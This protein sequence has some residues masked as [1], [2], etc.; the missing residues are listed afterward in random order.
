MRILTGW[1]RVGRRGRWLAGGAVAAVAGVLGIA[2]VLQ[3]QPSAACAAPPAAGTTHRGKATFYTLGGGGGN[4]S[5]DGPPV[6]G[7][8][9]ALGPQQYADAAA[10]GGYLDVTGPKG[11][12]RVK[13]ID[14]CPECPAE[15]IDLSAAAF[16]KIADPVQGVASV[17]FRAVANPPLPGPLTFRVKEGASRYWFALRVDN[18]GNPLAAVRA[19]TAGGAFRNLARTDYNYWLADSGLGPGPFTIEV[20]DVRGNTATVGGVTL[21]PG[22][23]QTSRTRL[24]GAAGAAPRPVAGGKATSSPT[25]AASPAPAAPAA[26]A[27]P[28]GA[29]GTTAAHPTVTGSAVA[30]LDAPTVGA[31]G[32]DC[33]G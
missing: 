15:H 12:V 7:L 26:P 6:D 27:S 3:S 21:R 24:Y 23:T 20:T 33:A 16:R 31:T 25:P 28:T 22:A 2:L 1:Q 8:F 18:T 5:Y 17:T 29:P 13:I 19:K 30:S 14:Q 32:G 9:V 4:C 10:C 11:R